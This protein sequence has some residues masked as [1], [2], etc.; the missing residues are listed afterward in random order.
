MPNPKFLVAAFLLIAFSQTPCLSQTYKQDTAVIK[1]LAAQ[2]ARYEKA[3][4]ED[5]VE[6]AIA[7]THPEMIEKMGGKEYMRQSFE[8]GKEMRK[9]YKM[10]FTDIGFTM[11]DSVLVSAKSYQAA[12]PVIVT[13]KYEDGSTND[14]HRIMLA[15]GDIATSRWYFLAIA[16]GEIEKVKATLRFIDAKLDIPE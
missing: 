15:Y 16:P 11:P 1:E 2:M 12:F 5:D 10:E 8:R 4:L 13:M 9:S 7:M 14:D 6:A 3:S